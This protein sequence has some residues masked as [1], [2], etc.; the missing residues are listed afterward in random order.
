M[1]SKPRPLNNFSANSWISWTWDLLLIITGKTVTLETTP[2][3]P[4]P[5]HIFFWLVYLF[6]IQLYPTFFLRFFFGFLSLSLSL[7][8]LSLYSNSPLLDAENILRFA[9]FLW[10]IIIFFKLS[11]ETT[12]CA[13]IF[14]HSFYLFS[15][16]SPLFNFA[17]LFGINIMFESLYLQPLLILYIQQLLSNGFIFFFASSISWTMIA[18]FYI[19]NWQIGHTH[20]HTHILNKYTTPRSLVN[21][22]PTI[23]DI[24]TKILHMKSWN[25]SRISSR[26][27]VSSFKICSFFLSFSY[28][29]F[30]NFPSLS[31]FIFIS[32]IINCNLFWIE[33]LQNNFLCFYYWMNLNFTRKNYKENLQKKQNCPRT[34]LGGEGREEIVLKL[35]KFL[36]CI[37]VEK[38]KCQ[39]GDQSRGNAQLHWFRCLQP[40]SN[41]SQRW[42]AVHAEIHHESCYGKAGRVQCRVTLVRWCSVVA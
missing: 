26:L 36:V 8:F 10:F 38:L 32:K 39:V 29:F 18:T 5:T 37:T 9:L 19:L 25:P 7:S 6:Y 30:F 34:F 3:H 41:V 14:F 17:P 42:S 20:T 27:R 12:M 16:L 15:L 11:M 35:H 28:F 13:C 40:F 23:E 31:Q 4:H 21:F 2:T 22:T 24:H 33:K 1:F